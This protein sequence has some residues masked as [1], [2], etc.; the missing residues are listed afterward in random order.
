MAAENDDLEV[1]VRE[2]IKPILD[3]AAEK[4]IG[5]SISK[6]TTDITSKLDRM[7]IFELDIDYSQS[8][9]AAKKKFRKS[10]LTRLLL[11]NLGNISEA[12]KLAGLDR[13]SLH[14]MIGSMGIDVSKIKKELHRPYNIRVGAMSHLIEGVL[15]NYRR[16]IHPDKL[17]NI[18]MNVN[19]IS[20]NIVNELPELKLGMKEAER[21]FERLFFRRVLE[22][23][24]GNVSLAARKIGLR[25]ETLHRKLK[26]LGMG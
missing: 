17:R 4:L 23:A 1:V 15:D 11:L 19:N 5:A 8:Y 13:R 3:E 12:A 24:G 9:A 18:Y 14:R 26:A 6:L 21:E 25:Y 20:E 10:Y 7:S 16:I 22:N 2:K